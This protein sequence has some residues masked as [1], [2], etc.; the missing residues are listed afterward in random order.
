MA[1]LDGIANLANTGACFA[2]FGR[3][4]AAACTL[5]PL[6]GRPIAVCTIRLHPR[7]TPAIA[8]GNAPGGDRRTHHQTL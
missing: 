4:Q 5:G 3:V 8:G 7:Q 2:A 1:A 6:V